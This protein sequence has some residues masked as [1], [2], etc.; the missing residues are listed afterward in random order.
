MT[1]AGISHGLGNIHKMPR[2]FFDL[3]P[4]KNENKT[5]VMYIDLMRYMHH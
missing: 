1:L 5:L 2:F 4:K 3:L